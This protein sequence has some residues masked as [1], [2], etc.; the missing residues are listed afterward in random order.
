MPVKRGE[1]VAKYIDNGDVDR[2]QVQPNGVD[3]SIGKL[4]RVNGTPEVTEG[5]Y[6]KGNRQ[7]MQPRSNGNYVVGKEPYIITYDEKIRI[8]ADCVGYVFPRSRLARCGA[9]LT[10]ALWDAGYE[11]KGEGLLMSMTGMEIEHGMNIA[12]IVFFDA[13]EADELY[14]GTHQGENL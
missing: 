4:E 11:G 5:D 9:F 2:S 7:Q 10:T 14:S 13:Q 8:P 3:L 12:Q 1:F 6:Y